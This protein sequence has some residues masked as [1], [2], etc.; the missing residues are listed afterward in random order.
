MLLLR[1]WALVAVLML[2]ELSYAHALAVSENLADK[3]VAIG[4]AA[5][6]G[7]AESLYP[8]TNVADEREEAEGEAQE[9]AEQDDVEP[10]EVGRSDDIDT[11]DGVPPLDEEH[12]YFASLDKNK[13]A[14]WPCPVSAECLVCNNSRF[15]GSSLGRADANRIAQH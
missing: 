3:E 9:G 6:A 1:G 8:D 7:D 4:A 5:K 10:D 15:C 13:G 2:C 11:F 14:A 12:A